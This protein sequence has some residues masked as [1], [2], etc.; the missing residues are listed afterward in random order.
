M[1][2]YRLESALVFN[3][4]KSFLR[5]SEKGCDWTLW[6]QMCGHLRS[7]SHVHGTSLR[8]SVYSNTHC[9]GIFHV[10]SCGGADSIIFALLHVFSDCEWRYNHAESASFV[11]SQGASWGISQNAKSY[12]RSW[13][14]YFTY[15]SVYMLIS[16]SLTLSPPYPTKMFFNYLLCV[17]SKMKE[18]KK[19]TDTENKLVIG[20]G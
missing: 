4:L 1:E 12:S 7:P 14:I 13:C 15:N 3:L 10:A 18:K 17:E 20:R 2:E 9:I 16:N 8:G 6:R 5:L 11:P 19:P